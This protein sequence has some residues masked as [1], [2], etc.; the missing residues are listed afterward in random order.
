MNQ[1][2][3]MQYYVE[4]LTSTMS[5][6]VVRNVSMQ[7]NLKIKDELIEQLSEKITE[8]Q[9]ANEELIQAYNELRG[10]KEKNDG[11]IVHYDKLKTE[12]EV[13]K[14]QISNAEVFRKELLKERDNHENTKIYYENKIMKLNEE[15]ESLKNPVK[16]KKNVKKTVA[17]EIVKSQELTEETIKDGGIF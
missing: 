5:D 1:E 6:C 14:K 3:Y 7:A 9:K 11:D 17:T 10:E 12:H 8:F 15:I 4:I 13:L 16:N 2:K